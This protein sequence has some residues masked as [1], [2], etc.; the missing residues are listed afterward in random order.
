M[1]G[2]GS[3]A[4]EGE[5]EAGL[6]VMGGAAAADLLAQGF[7]LDVDL[8]LLGEGAQLHEQLGG[9]DDVNAE[10]AEEKAASLDYAL[11]GRMRNAVRW[12][13][14]LVSPEKV[15]KSSNH[16]ENPPSY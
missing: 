10:H 12:L 7:E 3:R 9:V 4:A 2:E 6:F 1:V 15:V 13:R 11:N 16:P 8:M 5:E 14:N